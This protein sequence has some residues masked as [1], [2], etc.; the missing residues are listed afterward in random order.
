VFVVNGIA[1]AVPA[2]LIL[3]F[4][5]DRLQAP[6]AQE[7]LF[8][9]SYF[10][11]AALAMPLW[12]RCVARIG[13]A[14]TWLA[15]MLLSVAVFVFA[16][17]LGAGDSAAFVLVCTLSGVALGADLTVPSALLAGTIAANGDA[18]RA[19]G[20]YF[21]WWNFATKLN[22]ALAAGLALPLLGWLGY[23]PGARDPQALQ[24]LTW[25]YCLLPCCL[26]LLAAGLLHTLFLRRSP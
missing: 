11:C 10:V 25:A 21:G 1:S 14:R 2:T 4:V 5:Q 9:G 8:L 15:G 13:L 12:L 7:P 26:K 24:T 3:F 17:T 23:S 18:G 19:E 20:A 16:A 22:L 6:S